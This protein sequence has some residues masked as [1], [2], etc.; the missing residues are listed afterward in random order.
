MALILCMSF[1]TGTKALGYSDALTRLKNLGIIEQNASQNNTM[2]R[3]EFVKAMANA[4]GLGDMAY[5][6]RGTTIFP[7]IE[8]GSELSGYVNVAV[9]RGLMTGL[10]DGNFHPESPINY[11]QIC[12]IIVKALGYTD[13]DLKGTWPKNYISKAK[14]LGISEGISLGNN[15]GVPIWAA[16]SIINRLLDTNVKKTDASMQDRTYAEASGISSDSYQ[17]AL[18]SDPIYSTPVVALNMDRTTSMIGNID[19]SGNPT[20]IKNGKPISIMD[21]EENDVV[22]QVSDVTNTKKY[23]LVVDN[24]VSG[25]ITNF[26][27]SE[28]E[29]DGT[30]YQY[31]QGLDF[32][33]VLNSYGS[34]NVGDYVTIL[35]GYDGRVVDFFNTTTQDNSNFAYVVNYSNDMDEH[36][37]KLLMIDGNIREFKTQIDPKNYKGKLV[38]FSK[39]DNDTVTFNGLSYRDTGAHTVNKDLR[40]L[41]G[42]YVSHNVKIFNVISDNRNN[43]SDSNVE[44][45]DW[46]ELSTGR[47]ESGKILYINRAGT[48]NDINFM[49]TNDLFEDKYQIG[50]VNDVTPITSNVSK[51][52]DA[53]G[54]QIFDKKTVGYQYEIVVD[55]NKK[56]WTTRDADEFY[57]SGSI[58]RLVM[59]NGSIND[60]KE[61]ISYETLGTKFQ[62]ADVNRV[63][64]NGNTYFL[65]GKPAVYFKTTE[66]DY[67]LKDI[68]DIEV[69]RAYKSIGIYLDKSLNNGGKVIAIVVQ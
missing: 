42:D 66:G 12:T 15:D 44:L 10:S 65:K 69:N 37:V 21:I 19:L 7:D 22:Y 13:D 40:M 17:Y 26:T 64:I 49:V 8:V 18:I 16:A 30:V 50:I 54:N 32:N 33:E 1:T 51:G 56:S 41:D 53:D 68:D 14:E 31:R 11:A 60:V 2:T 61:K 24:K 9:D 55:G 28:V 47:I 46:S 35:L 48:Y 67:I 59:S 20:I 6:Y 5:S 45:V 57:G 3:G 38:S 43:N 29:I 4:S 23:I 39:I 25:K 27:T 58:L 36:R 62:A 34:L 63:K 52:K